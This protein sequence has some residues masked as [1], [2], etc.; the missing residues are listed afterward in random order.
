M[1]WC[2]SCT[3]H[4]NQGF[5]INL[6]IFAIYTLYRRHTTGKIPL[7]VA[8]CTMAFLGTIQIAIRIS[9]TAVIVRL[10]QQLVHKRTSLNSGPVLIA[11]P[12][13]YYD[14]LLTE[15]IIFSINNT[16]LVTD[17]L[18]V[19]S[20]IYLKVYRCYVIWGSEWRVI[21]LPGVLIVATI[22]MAFLTSITND[23]VFFANIDQ[24]V[25]WPNMTGIRGPLLHLRNNT[26]RNLVARHSK[27][28]LILWYGVGP[29][30][31]GGLRVGL[32]HN[33]QN[34]VESRP[35]RLAPLE[36]SGSYEVGDVDKTDGNRIE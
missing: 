11:S 26:G 1:P 18:F 14:L 30:K 9:K 19:E 8:S 17:T 15:D 4:V 23:R 35:I 21:I 27:P 13:T 12:T 36:P 10:S 24:R 16:S 7:L 28:P 31:T 3:K 25:P 20:L 33:I 29:F 5:Y 2:S 32:G 22:V 6:F 34:H